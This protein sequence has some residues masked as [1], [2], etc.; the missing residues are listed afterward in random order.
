MPVNSQL[1]KAARAVTKQAFVPPGGGAPPPGDPAA[2][3]APPG[4]APPAGGAPPMDP[5]AMGGGAPPM[6]PAAMGGGA[7]PADPAAMG[8]APPADPAAQG[9]L[10]GDPLHQKLDQLITLMSQQAQA[11]QQ[12]DGAKPK[13][14]GAGKV[15]PA[16]LKQY[17]VRNQKLMTHLYNTMGLPLPPDIL[18]DP[19]EAD[20]G[21]QGGGGG[22]SGGGSSGGSGGASKSAENPTGIAAIQPI[23]PVG[24]H[25][26]AS[27]AEKAAAYRLI[28]SKRQR[29]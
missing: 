3:G 20:A 23:K 18:D 13:G 5:A 26:E 16:E 14:K 29:A 27:V 25:K 9:T 7:P 15:D 8:G 4:G 12:G 11:G 28:L 1:L 24:Q 21:G 22:D 10:P 17:M 19:P 6:D 2:Q